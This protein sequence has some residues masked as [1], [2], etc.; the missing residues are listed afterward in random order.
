MGTGSVLGDADALVNREM[1]LALR[2]AREGALQVDND[3]WNA[4]AGGLLGRPGILLIAG[5]G[6]AC[7]GRDDRGETWRA[8]GWGH[9]L[10]DRGSAFALGSAAMVAATR[11]ADGRDVPTALT[12]VV[13]ERLGLTDLREIFRR[14]HHDG[15]TRAEV[16]ALA[17]EVVR[18]AGAGDAVAARLVEQGAQ[19]LVE[20]VATVARRLAMTAPELAL[21]G[22][23]IERADGYRRAFLE[24]LE[25]EL[26]GTRLAADGLPPVLGAVLLAA[27][28]GSGAA[29]KEA[30]VERLR[31]SAA[32]E[33]LGA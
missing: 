31:A 15:L 5:T 19:G 6:S 30:F 13:R 28:L 12:A 32:R 11:D 26:P 24:R 4:H 10:D 14:V 21:T 8:G 23:L 33:G 25:R 1:L 18:L 20:M 7:L 29:P 9:L 27:R 22:G 17:P 16:A 3:A 2:A